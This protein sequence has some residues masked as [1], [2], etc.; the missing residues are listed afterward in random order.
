MASIINQTLL[1]VKMDQV[2]PHPLNVR[3]GDIGAIAS[4]IEADGFYGALIVQES[5][6]YIVVGNH[7]YL[8]AQAEGL[9]EL[10]AFVIDIDDDRARRLMLRDNRTSDIATNDQLALIRELKELALTPDGLA[11]T[12]FDGDDLDALIADVKGGIFGDDN[13]EIE[14][15]EC[16]FK[17]QYGPNGVEP[18]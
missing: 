9:E 11:D 10:P 12:G 13:K 4:S 17:W 16:G 14:C 6:G 7:R 3:Q 2:R 1:T 18:V 15:P 8:A 5:T